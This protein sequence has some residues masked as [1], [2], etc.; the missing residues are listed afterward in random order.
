F[1]A[2]TG[3]EIRREV[4]EYFLKKGE[5][6]GAELYAINNPGKVDLW[7]IEDKDLYLENLR[8]YRDSLAYKNEVERY[9]KELTHILNNLKRHI[10]NPEL[11]KIDMAYNA[12]KAGN[13]DFR[14]YLEFLM[15]KAREMII[16]VQDFENLY[17]LS[18]AMNQEEN[19]DFKK[20]N[21]ERGILI[22]ELKKGL[23]KNEVREL[24]AKTV[25]FKTKKISRKVF[26]G[27]LLRK[28]RELGLDIG[29]FPALSNYIVYVSTYEA[30]N[31]SLVMEELD[32]LE[33]A[34]K[35][36]LYQNKTQRQ[37]DRLSR[38][39]AILK[40]IFAITLT[41]IDYRYYLDNKSSFDVQ[42]YLKFIKK[43]AP[44][45]R[46]Q[47]RPDQNIG[48]LDDYREEISKFY[49]YSFKRDDVFMENM[50][51][52][53]TTGGMNGAVLMTGGFHTEN[54][55]DL[56]EKEK[57]SYVSILPKF[58]I[59]KDYESPYFDI[60]AGETTNIQQMLRSVI[61]QATML[62]VAS[63]LS[64]AIAEAVW[65]E[66]GVW[67]FRAA[68]RVQEMVARKNKVIL[69]DGAGNTL[70]VNG[71]PL[72]FGK[73]AE[74]TITLAQL[75]SEVGYTGEVRAEAEPEI[76]PTAEPP[77]EGPAIRAWQNAIA[78]LVAAIP[79]GFS[80]LAFMSSLNVLP[81]VLSGVAVGVTGIQAILLAFQT[82]NAIGVEREKRRAAGRERRRTGARVAIAAAT[83]EDSYET[84]RRNFGPVLAPFVNYHERVHKWTKK[85]LY[86]GKLR[87]IAEKRG[88]KGLRALIN[89]LDEVIA[90]TAA[91]IWA[92][93]IGT[94][95]LFAG[96]R[97]IRYA[98][99]INEL[100][101]YNPNAADP[102]EVKGYLKNPRWK[103]YFPERTPSYNEQNPRLF[104]WKEKDVEMIL[105]NIIKEGSEPGANAYRIEQK[106]GE[107]GFAAVFEGTVTK[108]DLRGG[109][110]A[111][112][113]MD[114]EALGA[115]L[116]PGEAEV[117]EARDII[118]FYQEYI[119]MQEC[120]DIEEVLNVYDAGTYEIN[121]KR[122][123]YMVQELVEG[124][125][126]EK[127]S[128]LR[129][130][131]KQVGRRDEAFTTEEVLD[132]SDQLF[133]GL[134]GIHEKGIIHS[135]IKPANL[136]LVNGKLKIADF[137]VSRYA[138]NRAMVE[139]GYVTGTPWYLPDLSFLYAKFGPK[140]DI[141]A[142]GVV[143]YQLMHEYR[144]P[145]YTNKDVKA[146]LEDLEKRGELA[147][148]ATERGREL[149]KTS[150]KLKGY[151]E[152]ALAPTPDS[153]LEELV[154]R[155]LDE[156]VS[157]IHHVD[158][159]AEYLNTPQ[160]RKIIAASRREAQSSRR[161]RVATPA[162]PPAAA[163][164]AAAQVDAGPKTATVDL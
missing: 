96:L 110:V 57:I 53:K 10:F 109:R 133:R 19:I 119:F 163:Q 43:Q 86:F 68:V 47:A 123:Y 11:L 23:S 144:I 145:F 131:E 160:K 6:H 161:A 95:S 39:L 111:I 51:F 28:A 21:N 70:E 125:D 67:S 158:D 60:L 114:P 30:V 45:Y 75:L 31:R 9:L 18:Q 112:K 105:P 25:D 13:M 104:K 77:E 34:I 65:G 152:G 150:L 147:K 63:F 146:K 48:R 113:I 4:A 72:E 126:L 142:A 103:E 162:A 29:K 121:G 46:I 128:M 118:R 91:Y 41:K 100:L 151:K 153:P 159:A 117:R 87:D 84:I 15:G 20:A 74:K 89:F 83:P 108:G 17:L 71:K 140:T 107:G 5:I 78:V 8:V 94:K 99:E 7:G 32:G 64:P 148:W 24:V 62:Q 115:G 59:K 85:H 120:N 97:G 154:G 56:F 22:N 82:L 127:E 69:T 58:R 106:L 102:E 141:F 54:L 81:L 42:N 157:G 143:L 92:P 35:E 3:G 132:I 37:L 14:D 40:N 80:V 2:I 76:E 136:Y 44:R 52:G 98:P 26:Y 66:A 49:E 122:Y 90:Y 101:M 1:T 116:S 33:A 135:D 130:R 156:D 61:A 124:T 12:Y 138:P 164:P 36:P 79:V 88:T 149:A 137:G 134:K 73:G 93:V 139:D 155:L 38:N 27:Y 129:V 55:L 16:N 50:H